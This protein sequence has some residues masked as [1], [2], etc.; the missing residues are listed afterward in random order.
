MMMKTYGKAYDFL[1]TVQSRRQPRSD[2]FS[3]SSSS[4]S[5]SDSIELPKTRAKPKK[6]SQQKA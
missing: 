6:T 2:V 1:A 4:A 3:D 5:T